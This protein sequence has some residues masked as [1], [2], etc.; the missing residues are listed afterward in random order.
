MA[1]ECW[2]LKAQ[3]PTPCFE[4]AGNKPCEAEGCP[5]TL[6]IKEIEQHGVE[7]SLGHMN[8]LLHSVCRISSLSL[9]NIEFRQRVSGRS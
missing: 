8:L 2:Q 9:D 7:V 4:L 3:R 1:K 5:V 6:R